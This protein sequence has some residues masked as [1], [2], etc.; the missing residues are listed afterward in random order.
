MEWYR[1]WRQNAPDK[2]KPSAKDATRTAMKSNPGFC[3]ES[4]ASNEYKTARPLHFSINVRGS[5]NLENLD[6]GTWVIM[7]KTETTNWGKQMRG[8]QD[9]VEGCCEY[10][11]ETADFMKGSKYYD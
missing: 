4:P 7:F 10:G 5:D 1:D 6:M 8:A 2:T 3:S 9:P 11:N